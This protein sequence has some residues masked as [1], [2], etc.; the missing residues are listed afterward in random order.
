MLTGSPPRDICNS[1]NKAP[2]NDAPAPTAINSSGNDSAMLTASIAVSAAADAAAR[3]EEVS[4]SLD[5][6]GV[7]THPLSRSSFCIVVDMNY[8][9]PD[10]EPVQFPLDFTEDYEER[11][12]LEALEKE[13]KDVG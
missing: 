1:V 7:T 8:A 4:A 10:D 9:F 13:E 6:D 12:A 2:M 3:A 5:V 11:K